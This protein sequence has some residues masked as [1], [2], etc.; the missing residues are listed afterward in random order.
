MLTEN[1][2]RGFFFKL[3]RLKSVFQKIFH[4]K[5]QVFIRSTFPE[6]PVFNFPLKYKILMFSIDLWHI[7]LGFKYVPCQNKKLWTAKRKEERP[8][9]GKNI[10][11]LAIMLEREVGHKERRIQLKGARVQECRDR[12]KK[13][14]EGNNLGHEEEQTFRLWDRE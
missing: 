8:R 6:F 7:L 5:I 12:K 3:I 11:R 4:V 1:M 9:K 10:E 13:G 2:S 14:K